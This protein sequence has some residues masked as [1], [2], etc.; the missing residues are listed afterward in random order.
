MMLFWDKTLKVE[1]HTTFFN[2]LGFAAT[3]RG[4]EEER[5]R[6]KPALRWKV[7][8][9]FRDN[10]IFKTNCVHGCMRLK[11]KRKL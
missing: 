3:S 2:I 5:G 11:W 6:G 10:R 4:L 8:T 9:A 1:I 7:L